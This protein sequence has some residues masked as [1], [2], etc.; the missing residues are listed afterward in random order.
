MIKWII[1]AFWAIFKVMAQYSRELI[2]ISLISAYAIFVSNAIIEIYNLVHNVV[3]LASSGSVGG[4][5]SVSTMVLKFYGLL[6]CI[7]F[8]DALNATKFT[9][10]SSITFYFSKIVWDYG[11]SL[12]ELISNSMKRASSL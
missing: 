5:V 1:E 3:N 11:I 10:I 9:L 4:G 8:I 12:Y 2:F 6:N 7:G